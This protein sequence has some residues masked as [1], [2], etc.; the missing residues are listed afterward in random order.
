MKSATENKELSPNG[1]PTPSRRKLNLVSRVDAMVDPPVGLPIANISISDD[2][3]SDRKQE[4]RNAGAIGKTPKR[5]ESGS[6]ESLPDV[7]AESQVQSKR[8][9]DLPKTDSALIVTALVLGG[10]LG[11]IIARSK[12]RTPDEV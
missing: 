7:N 6:F 2:M 1:S 4:V 5:L 10:M 11:Y 9:P 3:F 12:M 8:F